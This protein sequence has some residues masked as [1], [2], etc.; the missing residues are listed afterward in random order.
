MIKIGGGSFGGG[1]NPFGGDDGGSGW[2]DPTPETPS[3]WPKGPIE[4]QVVPGIE[5]PG[6]GIERRNVVPAEGERLAPAQVVPEGGALDPNLLAGEPLQAVVHMVVFARLHRSE[7]EQLIKDLGYLHAASG[8]DFH[9]VLAGYSRAKPAESAGRLSDPKPIA[10][11]GGVTW[12]YDDVGFQDQVRMVEQATTWRYRGGLQLMI[13]DVMVPGR[14]A[15]ST[16]RIFTEPGASLEHVIVIDVEEL[17]D[18]KLFADFDR[19]FAAL[20]TIIEEIQAVHSERLTWKLSDRLALTQGG[21]ALKTV[22]KAFKLDLWEAFDSA[23]S[24]G[25]FAVRDVRKRP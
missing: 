6:Q 25:S 22:A 18:K 11:A 9:V 2:S 8:N 15:A 17:K 12:Y 16:R 19:F 5:G 24:L 10:L 14:R 4:T 13:C 23:I 20:R 21:V 7:G 1:G 3:G